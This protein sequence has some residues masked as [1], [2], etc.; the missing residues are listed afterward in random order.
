MLVY[1]LYIIC[2]LLCSIIIF[3]YNYLY[4]DNNALEK[5]AS[6]KD[7]KINGI[8]NI[9]HN[10][11]CLNISCFILLFLSILINVRYNFNALTLNINIIGITIIFCKN[12]DDIENNKPFP[13]S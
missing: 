10:I 9:K 11:E 1:L 4:N 2:H 5:K 7:A 12:N 6:T 8:I 3:N 13:C